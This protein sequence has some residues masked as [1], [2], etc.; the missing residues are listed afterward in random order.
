MEPNVK[1]K[2]IYNPAINEIKDVIINMH[3]THHALNEILS[4][5]IKFNHFINRFGILFENSDFTKDKSTN[6]N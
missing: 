4:V 6:N 5:L 3:N 1:T 2:N